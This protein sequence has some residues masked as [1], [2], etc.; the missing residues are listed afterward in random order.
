VIGAGISGLAAAQHL[1]SQNCMVSVIEARD[2]IGGRISTELLG[3]TNGGVKVDMGA[4]W[5]H[6][7]GPGAG[8]IKAYKGKENPIYKIAKENKI[9]TVPTWLDPDSVQS[10]SYWWQ[11]PTTALSQTRVDSLTEKIT[12]FLDD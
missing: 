9:S 8:E 1:K 5:I 7:I 3:T 4:S 10:K 2:R 12:D 11:S 6:G